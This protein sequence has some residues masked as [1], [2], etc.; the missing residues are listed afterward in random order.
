MKKLWIKIKQSLQDFAS[1]H[2]ILYLNIS[3]AVHTSKAPL[4]RSR[5]FALS[6][7]ADAL[8]PVSQLSA[9][10]P[11][12]PHTTFFAVHT[13]KALLFRSRAFALSSSADALPPVS[14]LSA[15]APQTPHTTFFAVHTS[16]ALLFRS[17]AF[18]LSSSADALPPVS[19]LS[20]ATPQRWMAL[21]I[22]FAK[23]KVFREADLQIRE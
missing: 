5:A 1:F 15:A 6:S 17:R 13:S 23:I 11:Q 22:A 16:K 21:L 20:A 9:A 14:Q 19:Q 3:F 12:T 7:S 8:P 10:A 4:F 2:L 18:A